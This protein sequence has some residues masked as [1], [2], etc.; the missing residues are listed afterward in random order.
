[1]N[2]FTNTDYEALRCGTSVTKDT[3]ILFTLQRPKFN[4]KA[5]ASDLFKGMSH[6]KRR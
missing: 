3:S 6:K 4:H 5:F 2:I 1:M